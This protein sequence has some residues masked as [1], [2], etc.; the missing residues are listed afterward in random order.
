MKI[1]NKYTVQKSRKVK[2]EE[3]Q[4]RRKKGETF[5]PVVH[6]TM[7]RESLTGSLMWH[8]I[9]EEFQIINQLLSTTIKIPSMI[10]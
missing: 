1:F 10:H 6:K 8:L 7:I 2:V 4:K 5:K 9:T 3:T